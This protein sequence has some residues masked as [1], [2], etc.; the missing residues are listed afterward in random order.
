M[1]ISI[2]QGPKPPDDITDAL[3]ECHQ[4]IRTFT[5]L[6]VTLGSRPDLPDPEVRDAAARVERYFR[7]ALPLHVRD[8]EESLLPRLHGLVPAVDEAL[9]KMHA[10][11]EQHHA[12]LEQLFQ[13]LARV[14]AAPP[15]PAERARLLDATRALDAAF[16][17]HLR[18]EETVIF[19]ALRDRVDA[20]TRRLMLDELRAR[21]S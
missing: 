9:A 21:R 17:P 8:E 4:R 5:A 12:L 16:E 15:D 13:A 3:L 1:L 20:P 2:G 14:Q 11:H 18:L 7:V 19:P 10:E 6:G